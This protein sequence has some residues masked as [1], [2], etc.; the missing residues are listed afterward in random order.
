MGQLTF[1]LYKI[2]NAWRAAV[3]ICHFIRCAIV[4]RFPP[5]ISSIVAL[6]HPP[7]QEG[8]AKSFFLCFAPRANG[9][10]ASAAIP[11]PAR[12]GS[13]VESADGVVELSCRLVAFRWRKY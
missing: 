6:V 8:L 11:H 5:T 2:P 3:L 7:A 10:N 12:S 1:Q 9:P 4:S 13:R